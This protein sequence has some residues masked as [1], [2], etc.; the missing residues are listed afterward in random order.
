MVRTHDT[1]AFAGNRVGFKVLNEAAQL[2]EQLGPV[3]TDIV[4]G[5]YTGRAM[6]PLSTIDLVGWD[7]HRAIVDN[8]YEKCDDEARETNKLPDYMAKLM[9]KGVLGNKSGGGFFGKDG[10]TPLA[11]D[12]AT[13]DYKPQSEIAVPEIP[14]IA[15]VGHLYAQGRYAEGMAIFLRADDDYARIARKVIG[16]YIAYAFERVGEATDSINEIDRIIGAGF[17]WAPPSVLVDVMTPDGAIAMIE[18]AGLAVPRTLIAARDAGGRLFNHPT[19]NVGKFFVA[20]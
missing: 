6:T 5:P 17:N 4:I 15:D 12:I 19:I 14:Y 18:E 1:P 10:K 13:G 16:G 11:L 9:E 7:I 8:V 20:G 2:A 3:L